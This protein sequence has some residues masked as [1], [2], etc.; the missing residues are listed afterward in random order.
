MTHAVKPQ[1]MRSSRV[2]VVQFA[3]MLG[4]LE[5][6]L[7]AHREAIERAR[8]QEAGLVVFPELS[9]TGYRL[10]DMV[11]EVAVRRDGDLSTEVAALSTGISLVVGF[12]EESPEH[13][14]YNSAAYFEDGRLVQVHRKVYLPTYG[15]FDEQRYF[16]RG[17]RIAAFGTRHGRMAIL[18]CEDMLHPTALT[19]AALDGASTILVPSASPARGVVGEG[20]V[21]ANGKH[22]ESYGR[23]MARTLGVHVVYANRVGVEDGHTFWGG[24]EIIGPDGVPMAKAAYYDPDFI[25]AELTE[26]AV[27][28]RRLQSPVLRDEDLDLTINELIRVRGRPEHKPMVADRGDHAPRGGPPPNR[29]RH[30]GPPPPP[31]PQQGRP[32]RGRPPE[33]RRRGQRHEQRRPEFNDPQRG[34]EAMDPER[35]RQQVA[36]RFKPE[37]GERKPRPIDPSRAISPGDDPGDDLP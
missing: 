14:F 20:E 31:P 12:V 7:N 28:R 4:D 11:P 26:D 17:N 3:P 5:S 27:R 35:R 37:P 36:E 22:W 9:L 1:H 15:M 29:G 10:K 32:G 21:D 34:V 6:N 13:H 30:G 16:A 19:L 18:I 24:S 23:A 8:G 25:V 2:A 33:R